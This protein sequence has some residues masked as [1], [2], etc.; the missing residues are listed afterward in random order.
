MTNKLCLSFLKSGSQETCSRLNESAVSLKENLNKDQIPDKTDTTSKN[1]M[2]PF[3]NK[4]NFSRKE[5]VIRRR[6]MPSKHILDKHS[7]FQVN[8]HVYREMIKMTSCRQPLIFFLLTVTTESFKRYLST[9]HE[10]W[11]IQLQ[12]KQFSRITYTS[13]RSVL[14]QKVHL[15]PAEDTFSFSL[16]KPASKEKNTVVKGNFDLY[17]TCFGRIRVSRTMARF[18]VVIV[19]QGKRNLFYPQALII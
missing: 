16:T 15:G 10:R 17:F 19:L 11:R 5:I 13:S 9:I 18:C 12:L 1:Y 8:V 7:N 6:E 2:L 14:C 3:G 4:G